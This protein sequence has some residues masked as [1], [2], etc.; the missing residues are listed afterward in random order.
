MTRALSESTIRIFSDLHYGD[1]ASALK[2][3][4]ALAP[5][6][7]GADR[8]VLNGDTLDTRP[9][10]DPGATMALRAEVLGYLRGLGMPVVSINGNH[11]PDISSTDSLELADRRVFVTHGDILFDELVPW[12]RDADELGK[13]ATAEIAALAPE[14][15]GQLADQL[16]AIHRA[17][18]QIPQRHQ[19][20]RHGLK[21]ALG[22]AADT[23][24]PPIR[25]LRVLRAWRQSPARAA[26]LLATHGLPARF[27]VMG[28]THRLGATQAPGGVTVLNTGSFCPPGQVGAIDVTADRIALRRIEKRGAA[29]RFGATLAE[30]PLA[31][32]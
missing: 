8:I 30:F 7:E 28:H 11:D 15:R 24:W 20:E 13:R 29:L 5:L 18:A 21:Y 2:S 31:A 12:S 25:I 4:P 26:R 6:F 19:S 17:A 1:R 9:S 22:F 27:F 3:L 32:G 14:R 23:I 16:A 10:R